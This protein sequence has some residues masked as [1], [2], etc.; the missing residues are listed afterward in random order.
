[1]TATSIAFVDKEISISELAQDNEKKRPF[2]SASFQEFHRAIVLCNNSSFDSSSSDLPI[3]ERKINGDS[4]DSAAFL[5][6][7]TVGDA[8]SIRRAHSRAFQIPFNSSN[9][10]MVSLNK[11]AEGQ[12]NSFRT[13]V[14]GAPEVLASRCT[15]YWSHTQERILPFNY[16]AQQELLRRQ[17]TW[18]GEG[19]RVIL[20]ATGEVSNSLTPFF[21]FF[22]MFFFLTDIGIF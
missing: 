22:H 11:V 12:G 3:A 13:F 6:G 5:L 2:S 16:E 1:M 19:K 15:T 18:S 20:I 10:F 17:N 14:K 9:K 7:E 4:T 8:A 21:F